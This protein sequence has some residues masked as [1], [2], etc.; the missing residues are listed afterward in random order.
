MGCMLLTFFLQKCKFKA[1]CLAPLALQ[2]VRY[3]VNLLQSLHCYPQPQLKVAVLPTMPGHLYYLLENLILLNFFD[4][5]TDL[6]TKRVMLKA[7]KDIEEEEKP[8]PRASVD[9]T[10]TKNKTLDNFV[11]KSR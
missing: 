2:A 8:L 10:N 9:M 7:S 3:D 11:T 5:D 6:T 4:L 1:W